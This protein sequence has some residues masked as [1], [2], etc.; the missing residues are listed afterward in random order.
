MENRIPGIHHVTAIAGDP[1]VER[2]FAPAERHTVNHH[3]PCFGERVQKGGKDRGA[4][5]IQH[6]IRTL[7]AGRITNDLLQVITARLRNRSH[8]F[9]VHSLGFLFIFH[10][11]D[12]VRASG[13]GQLNDSAAHRSRCAGHDHPFT[14]FEAC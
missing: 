4:D 9:P 10:E 3:P 13:M 6:H 7:P 1:Q 11:C 14:G 5:S 12:E 8:V 2:N